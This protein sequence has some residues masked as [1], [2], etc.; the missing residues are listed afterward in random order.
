MMYQVEQGVSDR[1][2]GVH[3]AKVA[4]FPPEVVEMARQKVSWET[5]IR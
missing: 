3:V 1:S 4:N 5:P 2:F